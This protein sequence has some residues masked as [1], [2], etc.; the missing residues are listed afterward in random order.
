M[1][2]L[3]GGRGQGKSWTMASTAQEDSARIAR[4]GTSQ[5]GLRRVDLR[6]SDSMSEP[7][8]YFGV[9]WQLSSLSQRM[10]APLSM[11]MQWYVPAYRCC[12]SQ[13][14]YGAPHGLRLVLVSVGNTRELGVGTHVKVM[15]SETPHPCGAAPPPM[16]QHTSRYKGLLHPLK[17]PKSPDQTAC[18]FQQSSPTTFQRSPQ[19]N[20]PF[21]GTYFD[22]VLL[23]GS[24]AKLLLRLRQPESDNRQVFK[25]L[26]CLSVC[27]SARARARARAPPSAIAAPLG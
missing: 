17:P 20:K 1:F 5:L 10:L 23:L 4:L 7:C 9:C 2:W 11:G 6:K 18:F 26:L 12:S 3:V 21:G 14:A 19:R 16:P 13:L 24:F 27:L 22:I 25:P 15:A 8:C